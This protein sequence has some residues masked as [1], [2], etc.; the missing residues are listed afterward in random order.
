MSTISVSWFISSAARAELSIL[1][2]FYVAPGFGSVSAFYEQMV[3]SFEYAHIHLVYA[4][5]TLNVMSF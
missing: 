4:C 5:D 2:E 3:N 1:L